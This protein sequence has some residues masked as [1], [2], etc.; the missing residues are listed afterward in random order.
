MRTL[1]VSSIT[2]PMRR[3]V[4]DLGVAHGM[5]VAVELEGADTQLDRMMLDGISDAITHL[6][7]NSIAHGIEPAD[8]RERAG[9]PLRG[10]IEIRA[11][12]HGSV[13]AIAVSDDGRGVPQELLGR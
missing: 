1:P 4:R 6:L 3:A 9:K 10:R 2:G 5:D 11:E 13:V 7:R 12:Q 8:E